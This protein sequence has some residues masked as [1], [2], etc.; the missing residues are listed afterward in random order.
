M[1]LLSCSDCAAKDAANRAQAEH[2]AFLQSLV[3]DLQNKLLEAVSPGGNARVAA[4][5]RMAI[6]VQPREPKKK[7][8]PDL[9]QQ[10]MAPLP[11]HD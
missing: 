11:G 1:G 8:E 5:G 3:R 2:V 6:P 4:A 7:P 10:Q 9:E